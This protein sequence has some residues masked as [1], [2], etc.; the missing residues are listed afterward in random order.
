MWRVIIAD[1]EPMARNRVRRLLDRE[2]DFTIAAECGDGIETLAAI[3]AAKP[4]L[5]LLD[6]QMPGKD[7]FQVLE[8]CEDPPVTIFLTAFDEY[9]VQAFEVCALEYVLK[10]IDEDR[11]ATAIERARRQ[12]SQPR[13]APNATLVAGA[14]PERI[15]V[16]DNGKVFVIPLTAIDWIESYG[17]YARI[18]IGERS[19]LLRETMD[20]LDGRLPAARFARI[21]RTA[22]VNVDRIREVTPETF[23]QA[24]VQLA[25]GAQLTVSRRYRRKLRGTHA[26]WE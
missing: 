14:A 19:V 13:S 23:G 6:I 1:D 5:L 4:D 24:R 20:A 12:L 22:I 11:F 21:H 18:H 17:N 10:P 9:A 2:T 26:I 16:R 7:G 15:F 8:S 3:S 25:G